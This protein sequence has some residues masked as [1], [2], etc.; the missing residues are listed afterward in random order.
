MSE[1]VTEWL[2][3]FYDGELSERRQSMVRTHLAECPECQ[4]ELEQLKNLSALLRSSPP[5]KCQLPPDRFVSQVGL[6]LERRPEQ[7][8]WQKTLKLGWHLIP[9]GLLGAWVFIQVVAAL[10]GAILFGLQMGLGSDLL[11]T[12]TN[13]LPELSQVSPP[14]LNWW[15]P[16]DIGWAIVRLIDDL[17]PL[18]WSIIVDVLFSIIIGIL[19]WS[20]LAGWLVSRRQIKYQEISTE[21]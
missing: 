14:G 21:H 5:A 17:S 19:Y 8:G 9:V 15:L 2:P 6:Q 12:V 10:S 4:R 7:S 18:T 16:G 1:H 11:A 3:A 20:W 13:L